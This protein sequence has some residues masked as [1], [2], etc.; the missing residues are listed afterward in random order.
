MGGRSALR[1]LDP[2]TEHDDDIIE[3]VTDRFERRL[4]DE[5]GKLR[6][7][8]ANLRTDMNK[9]FGELRAEIIERN[10]ELLK[11]GLVFWT[12]QI[13]VIAALLA[14]MR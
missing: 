4:S 5:C 2:M 13:G 9:G 3:R 10:A 6:V 11:W 12:T 14:L 7:E 1:A 8:N